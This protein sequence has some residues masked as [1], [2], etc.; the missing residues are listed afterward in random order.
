MSAFCQRQKS[1]PLLISLTLPEQ[2]TVK[3]GLTSAIA[4][5]DPRDCYLTVCAIESSPGSQEE[6]A[7][8]TDG[9]GVDGD[10]AGRR[11]WRRTKESRVTWT[12]GRQ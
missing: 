11:G 9:A 7:A 2:L 8:S 12:P 3:D 6:L 10:E 1:L 5:I 4:G